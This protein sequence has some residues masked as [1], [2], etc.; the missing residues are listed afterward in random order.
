MPQEIKMQIAVWPS[1]TSAASFRFIL[2]SFF[3][4]CV[5][6]FIFHLL[7]LGGFFFF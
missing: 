5:L 4:L 1:T 2:I 7:P 6:V 3:F